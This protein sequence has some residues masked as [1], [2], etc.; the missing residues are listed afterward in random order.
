MRAFRIRRALDNGSISFGF[1]LCRALEFG[2]WETWTAHLN[3]VRKH[4]KR[5][6][7]QSCHEKCLILEILLCF[8]L[9]LYLYLHLHSPLRCD[10]IRYEAKR[11]LGYLFYEFYAPLP[12]PRVGRESFRCGSLKW[13]RPGFD[14]SFT[15]TCTHTHTYG[16]VNKLEKGFPFVPLGVAGR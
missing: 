3:S 5:S 7:R 9:Y 15:H 14:F 11:C 8:C 16:S 12:C 1:R 6:P 10:A 13:M 4:L 2:T